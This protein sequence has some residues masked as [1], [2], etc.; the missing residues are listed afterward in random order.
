[1]LSSMAVN[2]STKQQVQ[3]CTRVNTLVAGREK[4]ENHKCPSD[5]LCCACFDSTNE[6]S[7]RCSSPATGTTRS[8]Y[9]NVT[10]ASVHCERGTHRAV[11]FLDC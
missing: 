9:T 5:M 10:F 1:M 3:R 8:T 11:V 7:R 4:I 6:N 2:S